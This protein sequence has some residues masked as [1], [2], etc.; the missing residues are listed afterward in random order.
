MSKKPSFDVSVEKIVFGGLGLCRIAGKVCFVEDVVV[1]EKIRVE[2]LDQK[3][4]FSKGK[5]LEIL[6]PSPHRTSPRCQH[7]T[8]CGGC[9]YQHMSYEEEIRVKNDQIKETFV[10]AL[11]ISESLIAPIQAS[12]DAYGYRNHVTLH[13]GPQRMDEANNLKATRWGFYGRDNHSIIG[14]RD[15]PIADPKIFE[16]LDHYLPSKIKSERVTVW[17]N[18]QGFRYSSG[19]D[20]IFNLRIGSSE[21]AASSRGFFQNHLGITDQLI[22]AIKERMASLKPDLVLDLYAGVGALGLLSSPESSQILFVE[23]NPRSIAALRKNLENYR[24]K[25]QVLEGSV[26][27][28][29]LSLSESLQKTKSAVILDP[30]REGLSPSALKALI[31]WAQRRISKGDKE[32]LS[33]FYVSCDLGILARDLKTL[34]QNGWDLLEILPFDMFPRTRHIETLACLKVKS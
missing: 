21:I 12:D 26:E 32:E 24:R 15:C 25:A 8:V 10:R 31:G 20:I 16:R 1:G 19:E 13:K 11:G 3:R 7:Y 33:V 27:K 18:Q 2:V 5:V 22:A 28:H 30:P 29:W 6:E 9:Q 4:N 14:I 34:T 23:E 17:A